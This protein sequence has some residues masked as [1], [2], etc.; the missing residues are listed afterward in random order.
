MSR[1]LE[2]LRIVVP[3]SREID[4][5]AGLLEAEGA[6]AVRCP[7]VQIL[8]V[9]DF[10]PVDA[11]TDRLLAGSFDDVVLFTGEGLRRLAKRADALGR[12][13][14]F[15]SSVGHVRTII[16]GPK[17]ARA[18]RELA[19]AP[20]ISAPSPTSQGLIEVFAHEDIRG[21][22]IGVQLYPGQGGEGLV[23]VLKAKGATV[24]TVTPY[25]YAS[26]TETKKVVDIIRKMAAG[27]FDMIVFTSSPQVER[28]VEVAHENNLE[29]A[30][31]DGLG[32]IR[33]A[34]I[35]PVVED[36]LKPFGLEHV[37]APTD[38]FHLKPLMRAII[39]AYGR[40]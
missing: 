14:D 13:P 29:S 31:A 3:E 8:D 4:L 16:R 9:D 1:K 10:S 36:A 2:G 35:G 28:L 26:Q 15:V 39:A 34:A 18:L 25:R 20:T 5:L 17:P 23:N 19:L 12:K 40:D 37:I 38:A 21:R 30:L 6:A 24:A 22:S 33:V 27:A 11:W 32:R 7:L